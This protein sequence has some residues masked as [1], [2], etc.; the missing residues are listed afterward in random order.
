MV[1]CSTGAPARSSQRRPDSRLLVRADRHALVQQS[2]FDPFRRP[3]CGSPRGRCEAS[4]LEGDFAIRAQVVVLAAQPGS[5]R[6]SNAPCRRRRCASRVAAELHRQRGEQDRLAHA[7]RPDDTS[8]WPT[9]PMCVTNRNGV[10]PSVRVTISGGPSRWLFV[11]GPPIPRTPASCAPGS[12]STMGWRTL[13][14]R[15]RGMDDSHASTALSVSG[16]V[17][18]PRPWMTRSTMR[19]FSSAAPASSSRP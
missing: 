13:R 12:A 7:G 19:S 14:R 1:R 9:S 3:R 2:A 6:A 17:T 4:G 10:A 8:V 11:P 16:M 5:W 18:K 15:V